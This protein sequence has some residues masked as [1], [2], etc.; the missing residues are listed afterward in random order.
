MWISAK[1]ERCNI[2]RL[3]G[4]LQGDRKPPEI[5]RDDDVNLLNLAKQ[6]WLSGPLCGFG[7]AGVC[8]AVILVFPQELAAAAKQP[9]TT[10]RQKLQRPKSEAD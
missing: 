7:V 6:R 9:Q 3:P 2:R 1:A 4:C 8:A 10:E 5:L